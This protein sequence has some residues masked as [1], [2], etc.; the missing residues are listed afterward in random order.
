MTQP[1]D[2]TQR[3]RTWQLSKRIPPYPRKQDETVK[4]MAT[5]MEGEWHSRE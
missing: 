3:V 1:Q 2:Y 5:R 4:Q